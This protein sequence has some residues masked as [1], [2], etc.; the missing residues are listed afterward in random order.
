[1]SDCLISAP[2]CLDQER[3]LPE[4]K[5]LRLA[6]CCACRVKDVLEMHKYRQSGDS[7]CIHYGTGY[8]RFPLLQLSSRHCQHDSQ[9]AG[10]AV[11]D[12]M[13]CK[14]LHPI[15]GPAN[16]PPV[17]CMHAPT[18]PA[19]LPAELMPCFTTAPLYYDTINLEDMHAGKDA[20]F[21]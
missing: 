20:L 13:A 2:A 8:K 4:S 7:S 14:A 19:D 10:I 1:M 18:I 21:R 12:C 15:H 16:C 17:T 11:P 3:L 6:L 9:H 5:M